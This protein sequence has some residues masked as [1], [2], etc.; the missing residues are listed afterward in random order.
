MS[1]NEVKT[2]ICAL[3]DEAPQNA[4]EQVLEYLKSVKGQSEE[5]VKRAENLRRIL[6]EDSELLS[7]LADIY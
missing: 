1:N 2:A 6:E 5:S 4:L 3:L 7:R